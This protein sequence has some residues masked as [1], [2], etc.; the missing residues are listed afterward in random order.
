MLNAQCARLFHSSLVTRHSSLR[1]ERPAARTG[2][3]PLPSGAGAS[4]RVRQRGARRVRARPARDAHRARVRPAAHARVA[5]SRRG[6]RRGAGL[7]RGLDGPGGPALHR[8]LGR[9]AVPLRRDLPRQRVRPLVRAAARLLRDLQLDRNGRL[10]ARRVPATARAAVRR[11]GARAGSPLAP[12]HAAPRP[13]E[14]A[15]AARHALP[16]PA[17]RRDRVARGAGLPRLRPA[18]RHAVVGR[19]APAGAGR[20]RRVVAR[21][22]ALARALRRHA[23]RRLRRRGP[24]RRVRPEAG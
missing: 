10:R 11:G 18:G 22:L 15:H 24:P 7:L 1:F 19:A 21:A 5:A 8:N 17:R 14:R 12:H 3:V 16:V 4:V 20:A 23:P 9:V 13:P 2:G 6:R